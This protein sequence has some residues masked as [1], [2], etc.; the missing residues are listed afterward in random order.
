MSSTGGSLTMQRCH[1]SRLRVMYTRSL[2][3]CVCVG[4]IH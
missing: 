3:V 2:C 1:V 4:G